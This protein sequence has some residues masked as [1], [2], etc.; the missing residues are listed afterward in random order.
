M[1]FTREYSPEELAHYCGNPGQLARITSSEL[2]EGKERGVHCLDFHTGSGFNFTVLPGRGMDIAFAEYRGRNLV[3]QS[4]TSIVAPEYYEAEGWNWIRGFFGGL[5]TTCGLL[6]VGIPDT[7]KGEP[8]GAHGRITY[9]P[10]SNVSHDVVWGGTDLYLLARGEMRE[11]RPPYY[12]LVLRRRIQAVAGEKSVRIHDTVRN[13]GFERVPHQIMYHINVGFPILSRTSRLISASQIITPRDAAADDAKEH[14]MVC[15][16][17]TPAYA[18]KVY[19]HSLV[20]CSD[21]R[22]WAAVVNQELDGGLGLYVKYDPDQLPLLVQWKMMGQGMY[23]VG[24]E[25]ANTQ[26]IGMARQ[27]GRGTLR[28]LDPGQEI[29]YVLEI[30]VLAGQ[31]EL[32]AFEREITLV[33]PVRPEFATVVL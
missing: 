26:G 5:L 17:P 21:G 15:T 9:T 18:E 29:D 14:Y 4:P 32:E 30:G 2:R 24:M 23:V 27:L 8:V 10:A 3:W 31:Q 22:C 1:F 33:S 19:Y 6:N 28:H 20:P 25:P 7:Y 16:D 11:T 13:E 12:N